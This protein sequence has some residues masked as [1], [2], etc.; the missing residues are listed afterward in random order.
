MVSCT[1]GIKRIW[2]VAAHNNHHIVLF[3]KQFYKKFLVI[4]QVDTKEKFD[5]ISE[6]MFDNIICLGMSKVDEKGSVTIIFSSKRLLTNAAN[7]YK[8]QNSEGIVL[9]ADYKW[10]LTR[11]GWPLGILGTDLCLDDNKL[12]H[13]M[14]PFIF[15]WSTSESDDS[16]RFL[17]DTFISTIALFYGILDLNVVCGTIDH[18]ASLR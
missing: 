1:S 3:K 7:S 6:E 17:I 12:V 5:S 13:S 4:S 11:N 9:A 2:C 8:K 15:A 16:F 10:K 18:S 14:I